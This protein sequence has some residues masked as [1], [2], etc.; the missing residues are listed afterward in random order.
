MLAALVLVTAFATPPRDATEQGVAHEVAHR[1]LDFMVP[2][3][4]EW[5]HMIR[6][7]P[8]TNKEVVIT[9]DLVV[10][11]EGT[12]FLPHDCSVERATKVLAQLMD[13]VDE[14]L[15]QL[16]NYGYDGAEFHVDAFPALCNIEHHGGY[17]YAVIQIRLIVPKGIGKFIQKFVRSAGVAEVAIRNALK[18]DFHEKVKL[19]NLRIDGDEAKVFPKFPR[20]H[21]DV[22]VDGLKST[23]IGDASCAKEQTHDFKRQ[24]FCSP[25]KDA[26]PGLSTGCDQGSFRC[27]VAY[28]APKFP[29][30]KCLQYDNGATPTS[31]G[32][33]CIRSDGTCLNKNYLQDKLEGNLEYYACPIDAHRCDIPEPCQ[34]V[35]KVWGELF[36]AAR[37]TKAEWDE[38]T[39][40]LPRT[41][42]FVPEDIFED[43]A[44]MSW[45]TTKAGSMMRGI[46][47]MIAL[48]GMTDE[49]GH[50]ADSVKKM[51]SQVH[52]PESSTA[53]W[54]IEAM[55]HLSEMGCKGET[56]CAYF[57][58]DES[59]QRELLQDF[60]NILSVISQT[61]QVIPATGKDAKIKNSA[62]Y[63]PGIAAAQVE[64]IIQLSDG[65]KKRCDSK[66]DK[67][68][69][70]IAGGG[71]TDFHVGSDV[72]GY[73]GGGGVV[74]G[75]GNNYDVAGGATLSLDEKDDHAGIWS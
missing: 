65:Q 49:D 72:T 63:L 29:K 46:G 74:V 57:N 6:R 37:S 18:G 75:K 52:I 55:E 11:K 66:K 22:F 48:A 56:D 5:V 19:K 53:Q 28:R 61:V 60:A 70:L 3:P 47:H 67:D 12:A 45:M 14:Y 62:E 34:P 38:Y 27:E 8:D 43:A 40:N 25:A 71:G 17:A 39:S 7:N 50:M 4:A 13:Q 33:L 24:L 23:A 44:M 42:C 41:E 21:C 59:T 1:K 68:C 36:E 73:V 16:K 30:C 64:L 2:T 20:C 10:T 54:T 58:G 31:Y 51:M 35:M 26:V 32:G 69:V 9:L 15:K